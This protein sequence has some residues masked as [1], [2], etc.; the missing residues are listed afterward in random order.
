[1]SRI[2]GSASRPSEHRVDV[3]GLGEIA[4]R[5]DVSRELVDKWRERRTLPDPDFPLLGG[6]VWYW[7]TIRKWAVTT[8]RLPENGSHAGVEKTRNESMP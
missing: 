7:Q 1:M 2:A 6:P 4:L 8:D 3:V 5:L